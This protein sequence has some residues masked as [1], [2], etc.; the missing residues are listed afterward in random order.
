MKRLRAGVIGLGVGEQHIRGYESHPAC[1]VVAICDFDE[2]KLAE[3]GERHPHLRRAKEADEILEDPEI[4]LVSIATW[5][6]YH[7]DQAVQAIEN[8]K[9]LFIE[10]PVCLSEGEAEHLR[11]MLRGHPGL[12]LSSN[13]ILRLCPRFQWLRERIAS[14]ALGRIFYV[15][16]DYDYGRL[17]KIT[18][19]WRGRLPFYS[20]VYGGAIHVVD[21]LLWLTGDRVLEVSAYGNRIAS[22]AS[23]FRNFDLVVSLLRF[24]S[25]MV[26][27]V[28]ANF[29][30]VHPHYH[31]LEIYGTEGTFLNGRER[32]VLFEKGETGPVE[33]SLELPYPGVAKGDLLRSFVESIVNG[34]EPAVTAEDV[35]ASMS[36]CFAIERSVHEGRPVAVRY[37]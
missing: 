24:E 17:H 13:L 22:E 23:A 20:V 18:H 33:S 4:D 6:N 29:G 9:H 1:E 14:G 37:L 30:C 12:R 16:G 8:G 15:E 19:G 26:G 31:A 3:V 25:G 34:G 36:V 2:A 28:T 11:E 35:F 5:D 21:L 32:G 10:K 27:K 7:H